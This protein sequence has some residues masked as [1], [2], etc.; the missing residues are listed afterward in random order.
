MKNPKFY[1]FQ[2]NIKNTRFSLNATENNG[3]IFG[4]Q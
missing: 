1:N 3:K 2:T 4:K